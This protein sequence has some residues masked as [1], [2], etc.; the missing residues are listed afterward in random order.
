M[1]HVTT[2]ENAIGAAQE[3]Q[4]AIIDIEA[5]PAN[6]R[7]MDAAYAGLTMAIENLSKL[8]EPQESE[9]AT[10]KNPTSPVSGIE[11]QPC[12]AILL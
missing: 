9:P 6:R 1:N 12:K 5:T 3:A 8:I 4:Q 10:D 2:L 11:C 7:A